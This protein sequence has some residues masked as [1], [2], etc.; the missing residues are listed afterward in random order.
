M[1]DALPTVEDVRAIY[2]KA[3]RKKNIIP[4]H[5]N[6]TPRYNR[7][8]LELIESIS[9]GTDPIADADKQTELDKLLQ[10][11]KEYETQ[12]F[13]GMRDALEARIL[14][15]PTAIRLRYRQIGDRVVTVFNKNRPTLMLLDRFSALHLSRA[16]GIR[17]V[18][19]DQCVRVLTNTFLISSGGSEARQGVLKRDIQAFYGSIDHELL[20]AKVDGHA[21]VP[22]FVKQHVRAVVTAYARLHGAS[23]GIPDGVPSSAA[24]AEIYLENFDS[25]IRGNPEVALYVRYV[26]D[27]VI[28]TEPERLTEISGQID[29]LLSKVKLTK[30]E[31]KSQQ[32]VHPMLPE[33]SID[34]LGYKF[35]FAEVTSKLTI[36][37]LSDAKFKR[38]AEAFG[39]MSAFADA[40]ECWSSLDSVD[41]YLAMF[42]YLFRPHA[43]AD[44]GHG[45]RIV[46]GLA[47]S[48]RFL[49]IDNKQHSNFGDLLTF[50]RKEV[51]KRWGPM[52]KALATGQVPQC[53]CC[54][55]D[56]PRWTE[57][58]A[59]IAGAGVGF[60]VMGSAALPHVDEGLRI[61]VGRLLWS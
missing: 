25:A 1:R 38:Y 5:A 6:L 47:Y 10:V 59:V 57:L 18:G 50:A 7:K 23:R 3:Q 48:G 11:K 54:G 51:G 21:G 16:F 32:L 53:G 19:R 37:D 61:K 46:T 20:L 30:N 36:I 12:V 17:P 8:I 2:F 45:M 52:N 56:I 35:V 33:T 58:E 22:R 13:A 28:V 55:R 31:S 29:K 40:V 26:D 9:L 27:I 39:R 15:A 42:E 14:R 43:T 4:Q 24:L 44:V 41:T 60:E 34:Y 49:R